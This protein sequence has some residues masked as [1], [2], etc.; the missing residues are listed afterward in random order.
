M[1]T[2]PDAGATKHWARPIL[3]VRDL[4]ASIAYFRDHLAFEVDW[5]DQSGPQPSCGQVSRDGVSL[6][7]DQDAAFPKAAA[8][9]VVSVTL[10]DSPESPGLADLHR[11][12]AGSGG[13]IA[14]PPF[15]VQW[16]ERIHQMDVEDLDGNVLMYWGHVPKSENDAGVER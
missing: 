14:R 16:D 4:A 6:I 7:L 9:S 3:G 11:E 13:R 10:D 1:T 5:L 8:P 15:K 2:D 12:L